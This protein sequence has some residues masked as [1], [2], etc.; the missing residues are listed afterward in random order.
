MLSGQE[1]AG[2]VNITRSEDGSAD[3]SSVAAFKQDTLHAFLRLPVRGHGVEGMLLCHGQ[4]KGL[5]IDGATRGE[6]DDLLDI[7]LSNLPAEGV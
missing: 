7:C 3:L 2:A 6:E 1:G 4:K 5:P